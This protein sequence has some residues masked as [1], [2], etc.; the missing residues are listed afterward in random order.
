MFPEPAEEHGLPISRQL[1]SKLTS[2]DGDAQRGKRDGGGWN[3]RH[4][5]NGNEGTGKPPKRYG[6]PPVEDQLKID[7]AAAKKAELI[8]A[9][10][11][12][13]IEV[14]AKNTG[15]SIKKAERLKSHLFLNEYELCHYDQQG[16]YYY[17]SRLTPDSEVVYAF[18]KAQEGELNGEGKKWFK[19]LA[20][21]ELVEKRLM[22][23]GKHSYRH[24]NSWDGTKFTGDPPGAHDLAPDQPA[25]GTFPGYEE[26]VAKFYNLKR[27]ELYD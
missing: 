1:N 8:R 13:N 12:D 4:S 16:L 24:P 25:F 2:P 7:I 15:L 21:H 11:L 27:G 26:N 17:Y 9:S 6:K 14:F 23:S 5:D 3:H 19:Q 20:R 18:A 22:D 10:G